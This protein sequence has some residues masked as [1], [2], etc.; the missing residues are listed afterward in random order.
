MKDKIPRITVKIQ[1]RL[2]SHYQ[3]P[4]LNV[5]FLRKHDYV[6]GSRVLRLSKCFD[7]S[8]KPNKNHIKSCRYNFDLQ[9]HFQYKTQNLIN[10][11]HYTI[12][13]IA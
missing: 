1:G 13:L 7:L 9:K 8:L 5:E 12:F 11:L 3:D 10:K 2:L 4:L 6:I